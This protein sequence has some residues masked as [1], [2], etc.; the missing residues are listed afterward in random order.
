MKDK[1]AASLF[2][3][4]AVTV[5]IVVRLFAAEDAP[6]IGLINYTGLA[7]AVYT[8]ADTVVSEY[9]GQ[10]KVAL[11]RGLFILL[12]IP[13]IVVAA[14]IFTGSITLDARANDLILLITLLV[15][16]PTRFYVYLA[17]LYINKD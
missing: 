13:L 3:A 6:W 11:I 5:L 1:C 15:S 9:R 7:F 12:A 14:L 4:V 16:L 17:G 8:L 10:D 2:V